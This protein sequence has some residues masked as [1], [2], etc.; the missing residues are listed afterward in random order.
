MSEEIGYW[1]PA[2][3]EKQ[4]VA[5]K[6]V[7][8]D[9]G[10]TLHLAFEDPDQH[11]DAFFSISK[12]IYGLTS[13]NKQITLLDC[14]ETKS[15]GNASGTIAKEFHANTVLN[16]AYVPVEGALY[17]SATLCWS[18]LKVLFGK[19]GFKIERDDG[20][21]ENM[22][23]KYKPPDKIK[24][25]LAG[26]LSIVISY[27]I[28]KYIYPGLQTE[29][30]DISE[31]TFVEIIPTA[32][33]DMEYFLSIIP[34]LRDFFSLCNGEYCPP[35]SLSLVADFDPHKH[36]NG[37]VVHRQISLPIDYIYKPV[38]E[39]LL[40]PMEILIPYEENP[41]VFSVALATWHK[42]ARKLAPVRSLYFSAHYTDR[43]HHEANFLALAQAIEV[44]HRRFRS[45]TILPKKD[46]KE[47]LQKQFLDVLAE[48][49]ENEEVLT[50]KQRIGHL[51][52]YSLRNRINQLF[53]EHDAVITAYVGNWS[54]LAKR[55][56]DARNY[57]THYTEGKRR[58]PPSF[59][60]LIEFISVLSLLISL[61]LLKQSGVPEETLHSHALKCQK[62]K[63]MFAGFRKIG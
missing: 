11:K 18:S 61:S 52:E 15:T 60:D 32:P 2:G 31:L 4:K 16:G 13:S 39:K 14:F 1:W 20:D 7:Q 29:N 27:S 22:C 44:F 12:G 38:S 48:Y 41:E 28:D 63:W 25:D 23:L 9:I 24:F 49:P 59:R 50:F 19:T 53:V 3:Y 56:A 43:S 33:H 55:I 17:R 10:A 37:E 34:E 40:H 45:G 6:L 8:E 51:N 46:F 36:E 5:G 57:Y 21:F 42:Y 54:E 47:G 58:E 26:E 30:I 62:Y 35:A